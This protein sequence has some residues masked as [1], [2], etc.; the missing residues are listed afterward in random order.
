MSRGRAQ[1]LNSRID[2]DRLIG[3]VDQRASAAPG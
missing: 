2:L 3:S 1:F